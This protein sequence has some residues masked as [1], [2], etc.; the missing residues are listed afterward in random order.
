MVAGAEGNTE[1]ASLCSGLTV[2]AVATLPSD[3]VLLASPTFWTKVRVE[4][5]EGRPVQL[6]FGA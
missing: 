3:V 6:L 4:E 5:G 1:S 2:S